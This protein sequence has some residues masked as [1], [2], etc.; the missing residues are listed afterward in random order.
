MEVVYGIGDHYKLVTD[1]AVN[2]GV[3]T[4]PATDLLRVM[5]WGVNPAHTEKKQ[6]LILYNGQIMT[7]AENEEVEVDIVDGRLRNRYVNDPVYIRWKA[8]QNS[9]KLIHGT[10]HAEAAEQYLAVR[11][12]RPD[13]KV[14]ELGGNLGRNSCLIARLL[15]DYTNLVVLET[16][17]QDAAKLK[18]NRDVNEMTFHIVNAGLSRK[19][20]V[21]GG[22]VS[23]TIELDAPIPSGLKEVPTITW[24]ELNAQYATDRPFDTLVVDCEGALVPILQQEPTMLHHIHTILME[25][26]YIHEKDKIA[27]D[28]MLVRASFK[29]TY[30]KPAP[31]HVAMPCRDNFYEVWTRV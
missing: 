26:D 23:H 9:I 2:M 18:Q 31:G 21:Q 29:C 14:L 4:I 12:I 11:T 13:A 16:S 5:S 8:L 17:A 1:K 27:L 25:N 20:L 7:V 22:W 15:N 30:V 10:M 28:E 24:A 6:V 3:A 19:R